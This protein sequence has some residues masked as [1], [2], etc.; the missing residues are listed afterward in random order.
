M[1]ESDGFVMVALRK[2]HHEVQTMVE[3]GLYHLCI[4]N[5]SSLMSFMPLLS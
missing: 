5:V 4:V 2:R 3:Q 1:T